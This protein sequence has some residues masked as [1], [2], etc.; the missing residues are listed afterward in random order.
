MLPAGIDFSE[1]FAAVNVFKRIGVLDIV[2][3]NMCTQPSDVL[4]SARQDRT[5]PLL[6]N[7][8]V[9]INDPVSRQSLRLII[10]KAVVYPP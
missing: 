2:E 9:A 5:V 6:V 8:R 10:D 7:L 1:L 4:R 3:A